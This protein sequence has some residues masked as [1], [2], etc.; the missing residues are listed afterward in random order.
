[1]SLL[2]RTESH[3]RA[4]WERADSSV[5]SDFFTEDAKIHGL[6]EMELMGP[7]EFAAFHAMVLRQFRDVRLGEM[8]G[9]E[10]EG[11]VA[12]AFRVHATERKSERAVSCMAFLMARFRGE[13][14][15]EGMNFLDFLTLFEQAG[16][17]PPRTRDMCLLGNVLT[18]VPLDRRRAH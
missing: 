16:R 14:V 10:Q 4:L 13:K 7:A 18:L 11:R 2:D 1:M 12:M 6:E 3:L 5:V 8:T 17:L 9:V 15:C